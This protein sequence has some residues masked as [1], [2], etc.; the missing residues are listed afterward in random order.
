M[1]A[2]VIE[3]PGDNQRRVRRYQLFDAVFQK[4]DLPLAPTPEQPQVHIDA[5]KRVRPTRYGD[6]T[7]QHSTA[8]AVVHGNVFIIPAGDRILAE[9]RIAMVPAIVACVLS[10]GKIV[11][12]GVVAELMLRPPRPLSLAPALF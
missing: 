10:V 6:F 5:V 4:G 11:P 1:P 7:M 3:I 8:F 9:D 12:D 2:P